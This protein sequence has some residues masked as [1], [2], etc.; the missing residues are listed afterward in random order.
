MLRSTNKILYNRA[1]KL[2]RYAVLS[3]A[4][5]A[6]SNPKDP[7]NFGSIL[8]AAN[9][10]G[11]EQVYYTGTRIEFA[12]RFHTATNNVREKI[13]H[14]SVDSLL[15]LV[16]ADKTMVA[17]ELV[18]G[19]VPLPAF[20][21]PADAIYVFGPEDGSLDQ[22]V[23]DACDAVVYVPTEGCLNLAATVNILL[24]D[25]SAKQAL[26]VDHNERI[27]NSRDNNNRLKIRSQDQG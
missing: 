11:A 17:V 2:P 5:I 23:V 4:V 19:A 25:R 21:H 13:P 15:Q 18:E 16:S 9:C 22:A 14:Q 27:K 6:L 24:Y 26:P 3:S 7:T 20:E 12:N 10:F 1:F 8:R